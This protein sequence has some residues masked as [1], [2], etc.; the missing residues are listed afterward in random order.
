MKVTQPML[1]DRIQERVGE[2]IVA[3]LVQQIKQD[4]VEVLL[5]PVPQ[6]TEEIVLAVWRCAVLFAGAACRSVHG[7]SVAVGL[8]THCGEWFFLMPLHGG[9]VKASQLALIV[10]DSLLASQPQTTEE[11]EMFFLSSCHR[12][13]RNRRGSFIVPRIMEES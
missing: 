7:G 1:H 8:G 3:I 5:H 11:I 4:I 2:Q 6:T 10:T 9:I 12:P 13:W